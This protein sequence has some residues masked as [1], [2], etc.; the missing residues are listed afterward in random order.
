MEMETQNVVGTPGTDLLVDLL[1][2]IV[3][4]V[5]KAMADGKIDWND[6]AF[7][8]PLVGK[9]PAVG[10]KIQEIPGELKDLDSAEAVAL[11]SKVAAKAG[12]V[13]N[14]EKVKKIVEGVVQICLGG[15]KIFE[16]LK[17]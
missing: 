11:L 4:D 2:D 6:A 3:I 15:F 14:S 17:A 12:E 10:A 13:E 5:K 7:F 9:I 1:G 16:G 8:M